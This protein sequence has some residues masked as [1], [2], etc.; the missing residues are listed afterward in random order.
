MAVAAAA[1]AA[2]LLLAVGPAHAYNNGLARL[3]PMGERIHKQRRESREQRAEKR[4]REIRERARR[5]ERG[6]HWLVSACIRACAVQCMHPHVCPWLQPANAPKHSLAH[7]T[8]TRGGA[9]GTGWN[10]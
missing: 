5:R 9:L 8:P 7:L 1:A 2:V 4:V 6:S 10:T 3:P